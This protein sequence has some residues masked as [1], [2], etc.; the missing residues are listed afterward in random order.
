MNVRKTDNHQ[1]KEINPKNLVLLLSAKE[2]RLYLYD[3][4]EFKKLKLNESDTIEAYERD[5]PSMVGKF[6][7]AQAAKE[8][9]VNKFLLH[10][11][12]A[13]GDVLRDH[14]NA[15][16]F[17]LGTKKTNGHFN[18]ISKHV[19]R[20]T[21]YIHGNYNEHTMHELKVAMEPHILALDFVK[22]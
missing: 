15:P 18:K 20:V 2:A 17:I 8:I 6:S 22:K 16:L 9:L 14:P 10:I 4:I 7:N 12:H 21:E 11:D 5:L 3:G 13:L 19:K 1:G